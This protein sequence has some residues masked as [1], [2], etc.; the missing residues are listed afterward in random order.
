M[1]SMEIGIDEVIGG[2]KTMQVDVS[3]YEV[4]ILQWAYEAFMQM[5]EGEGFQRIGWTWENDGTWDKSYIALPNDVVGVKKVYHNGVELIEKTDDYKKGLKAD[6]YYMDG[7]YLQFTP[8]FIP[9]R[10]E[11]KVLRVK[12]NE[13]GRMVVPEHDTLAI[14]YYILWK[15]SEIER[16][17]ATTRDAYY[18]ARDKEALDKRQWLVERRK[19]RGEH[20]RATEQQQELANIEWMNT[21]SMVRQSW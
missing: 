1:S 11:A 2:L 3:R 17:S 6:E 10:I 5:S 13:D 18:I 21:Y 12:V 14:R 15:F 19:A 7:P 9:N 20:N 8:T 4:E 16:R